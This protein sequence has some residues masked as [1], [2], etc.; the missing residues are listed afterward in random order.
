MK[1][2][3]HY[4]TLKNMPPVRLANSASLT[5]TSAQCVNTLNCMTCWKNIFQILFLDKQT[6]KYSHFL[7]PVTWQVWVMQKSHHSSFTNHCCQRFLEQ[8]PLF[9]YCSLLIH[10]VCLASTSIPLFLRNAFTFCLSE[11]STTYVQ[12]SQLWPNPKIQEPRAQRLC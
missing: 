9:N 4:E 12:V 1:L 2:C 8:V 6:D 3:I 10:E 5:T 11:N 7:Y